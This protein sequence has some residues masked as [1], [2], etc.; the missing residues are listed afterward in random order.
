MMKTYLTEEELQRLE[1]EAATWVSSPAGKEVIQETLIRSRQAKEILD[2]AHKI[3]PKN[4]YV[5]FTL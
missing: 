1:R 3:D 5:V 4:P 2:E